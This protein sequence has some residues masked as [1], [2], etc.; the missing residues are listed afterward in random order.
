MATDASEFELR[1]GTSAASLK[2]PLKWA[3]GKRWQVPHIRPL[4][5]SHRGRRFVEPF[6]GGLAMALG[7]R[8]ERALLND[9]NPH[10][11]NFY[12]WLQRGLTINLPLENSERH[13]YRQRDRFNALVGEANGNSSEAAAI[14]YYLNR[15][16]FNGLCR[17]SRRGVFNVPFG[18]YARISYVT[19][20]TMYR[21]LLKQWIF[22]SGD[23][24]STS[25]EPSDFVYADPPYDASFTQYAKD[26]F[27]WQDQE[28][29]AL[30]LYRHR[31]PTVLVNRAT[32]R[33]ERLYRKLGFDVRFLNAPRRLSCTGDRTP[34]REIVASRNL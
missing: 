33:V 21:E 34:V 8:P 15:T 30:W 23:A 26:G 11:I 16:G 22:T 19:D 5:E 20:F 2:P 6:C 13:Y 27:G 18:R 10:L 4:W 24:E 7:L 31:G 1:S 25:I 3:G 12:R 9:V 17:F 28:R 29:T 32:D 14:F